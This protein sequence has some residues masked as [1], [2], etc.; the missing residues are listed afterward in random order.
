[1]TTLYA[2]SENGLKQ[3]QRTTLKNEAM[4]EDWIFEDPSIMGLDVLIIG[5]QVTTYNQ[6]RIDI[7][8]MER[9]GDLVI[10]ELKRD[11]T[12]RDVVAQTLDYASWVADLNAKEIHDI[13]QHK[14]GRPLEETY[15]E[16]FDAPL[17]DNLN[18]DH[19]M[20]IVASEFDASSK[21]IVEYLAKHHGLKINS[22]FFAVFEK[23]EERFLAAEWLMDQQEVVERAEMKTKAPWTGYY[24]VNAGDRHGYRSWE[25]MRNYGFIAAGGGPKYSQPLE[26]LCKGDA[27]YAYFPE[28][29]YVGFGI[30]TAARVMARNFKLADGRSLM[31][32]E[33]ELDDDNLLNADRVNDPNMCEYLVAV[34]WKN[35]VSKDE[36]RTFQNAFSNPNIV[37]KL[38]DTRTLEFL[39][40]EF[41]TVN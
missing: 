14:L 19:S 22:T 11:R 37:C 10:I 4:L 31:E 39:A 6:G 13:A 15:K 9:S 28:K 16:R 17:P 18:G 38:R 35:A 34:E 41:G 12:P 23:N 5:R 21:R 26:K 3:V 24:Y 27:L 2:I 1:M 30:V 33:S 8:A 20:I 32:I 36:A 40:R 25:D 29:G 7:L